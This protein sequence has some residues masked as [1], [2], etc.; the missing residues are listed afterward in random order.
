MTTI[1]G[2][3]D[4]FTHLS[5]LGGIRP[6]RRGRP[7]NGLYDGYREAI[8]GESRFLIRKNGLAPDDLR[9]RLND[10]FN[11]RF[12]TV[13][14]MYDAI[15]QTGHTRRKMKAMLL[16]LLEES[17]GEA[18]EELRQRAIRVFGALTALQKSI[19]AKRA[20]ATR[21]ARQR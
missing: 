6:P 16:D 14:Q 3:T 5:D 19:R 1:D 12:E 9:E 13:N 17:K 15:Q 4:L 18:N 7:N 21:K 10:S 11:H 8:G 20:W 2:T